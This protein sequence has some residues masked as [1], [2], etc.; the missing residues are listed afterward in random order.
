MTIS[1][2]RKTVLKIIFIINWWLCWL[3]SAASTIN[4][5]ES[6][7]K[8]AKN[9]SHKINLPTFFKS[10]LYIHA[11][12]SYE[13]KEI[14]EPIILHRDPSNSATQHYHE[15]PDFPLKAANPV[16]LNEFVVPLPRLLLFTAL[17]PFA[18]NDNSH[19]RDYVSMKPLVE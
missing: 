13:K 1:M 19:H 6:K 11:S 16:G 5:Y 10:N 17:M 18:E 12:T 4:L 14:C 7:R 2:T 3:S 8:A 9:N 15:P